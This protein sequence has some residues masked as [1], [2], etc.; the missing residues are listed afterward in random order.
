MIRTFLKVHLMTSANRMWLTFMLFCRGTFIR[1]TTKFLFPIFVQLVLKYDQN[2][3][4]ILYAMVFV[5]YDR[6]T[7]PAV[8]LYN[9]TVWQPGGRPVYC[10]CQVHLYWAIE[11]HPVVPVLCL[12]QMGVCC[13][14][15]K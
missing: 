12:Q 10:H 15:S 1:D 9:Y 6:N 11:L 3:I 5:A 13:N 4:I 14:R 2:Y 8:T 7:M